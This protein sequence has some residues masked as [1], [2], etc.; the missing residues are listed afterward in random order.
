MTTRER[1]AA[2]AA[3]EQVDANDWAFLLDALGA[4]TKAEQRSAAEAV[5][6]L[7]RKG[8]PIDAL[9][10][11][12]L[13]DEVPRRRWGAAYAWSLLGPVP[14]ACLS[15]LLEAFGADDGDLRWAAA[16]IVCELGERPSVSGGLRALMGS[17]NGM[18][19]KM[20]LYCLR[21]LGIRPPGLEREVIAALDDPDPG[22]RLA[23]MSALAQLTADPP[24]AARA[25]ARR[26]DDVEP[27]VRRAAAATLGRV[28][29]GDPPVIDAL[30]RA[31]DGDDPALARAAARALVALEGA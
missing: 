17:A 12:A 10:E 27:G 2:I 24:A 30:R 21:D 23:A 31:R 18:Q 9:L 28:G 26:L 7:G 4:P 13:A 11:R 29:A 8:H 20:A 25:L 3:R 15:V 5:A 19:R 16:T 22:V 1:L 14:E 6:A